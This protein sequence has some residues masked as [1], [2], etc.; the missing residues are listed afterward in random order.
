M[1]RE[2]T[3][4]RSEVNGSGG[5]NVDAL[6][7]SADKAIKVAEE[8]FRKAGADLV[9][10]AE[11]EERFN[12]AWDKSVNDLTEESIA[13]QREQAVANWKQILEY[14]QEQTG[15]NFNEI[16]TACEEYSKK[17]RDIEKI[18]GAILRLSAVD[19][20]NKELIKLSQAQKNLLE[21]NSELFL[22][23]KEKLAEAVE[24]F[25]SSRSKTNREVAEYLTTN[26]GPDTVV[27]SGVKFITENSPEE[28]RKEAKKQQI[29][30]IFLERVINNDLYYIESEI[31]MFKD[32]KDALAKWEEFKTATKLALS[33]NKAVL[34]QALE[35][36]Y[37]ESELSAA[38][39]EIEKWKTNL[40]EGYHPNLP[41]N[42]LAKKI[43]C[44]FFQ[45]AVNYPYISLHEIMYEEYNPIVA[46]YCGCKKN[47]D[48]NGFSVVD[49]FK[50]ELYNYRSDLVDSRAINMRRAYQAVVGGSRSQ[51]ERRSLPAY[52]NA[53]QREQWRVVGDGIVIGPKDNETEMVAW[54]NKFLEKISDSKVATQDL[55]I[56]RNNHE[57]YVVYT[58]GQAQRLL[59]QAN[60]E[61]SKLL[62][63]LRKDQADHTTETELIEAGKIVPELQEKINNLTLEVARWKRELEATRTSAEAEEENLE[64]R[65]K[66]L[67]KVLDTLRQ[68]NKEIL[69]RNQEI[70]RI[71]QEASKNPGFTGSNLK[72]K[73][74]VAQVLALLTKN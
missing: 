6:I 44:V 23:I 16:I 55:L 27:G 1:S 13:P 30:E 49:D 10:E 62:A 41:K 24:V 61:F 59:N 67:E 53:I 60:Q 65:I 71:L 33:V 39:D 45:G 17:W 7:A 40:R 57:E 74:A 19:P 72:E 34:G 56:P 42:E 20:K 21:I 43:M 50:T 46:I 70:R 32:Q 15:K 36:D 14:A 47:P 63:Q 12:Q 52:F 31:K 29:I 5:I 11:V 58:I 68:T 51:N 25:K 26:I 22:A 35:G 18:N 2:L 38:F 37:S 66:D 9:R 28:E 73:E 69:A 4:R 64:Q 3:G 8:S 54:Y 48:R